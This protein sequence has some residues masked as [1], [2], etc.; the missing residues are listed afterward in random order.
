[1]AELTIDQMMGKLDDRIAS[2]VK[3]ALE[4]NGLG[5]VK[6]TNSPGTAGVGLR[7]FRKDSLSEKS[8]DEMSVDERSLACARVVRYMYRAGG[9]LEAAVD[10][11]HRAGDKT[12]AESCE[13]A[14]AGG[15]FVDGG[16]LLPTEFTSAVI[17]LLAPKST[18][19]SFGVTRIPMN[20]GSITLPFIA[21][22]AQASYVQEN[23]AAT[24]SQPG[25]G[26]LQ[27]SD[28]KLI[29]LVATSND[30]L[31]NGG[32]TADRVIRDDIA[33]AM[34]VKM[35]ITL[36]RSD[37]SNGEPTG[38]LHHADAGNLVTSAG[39]TTV[40]SATE[41]LTDAMQRLEDGEVELDGAGWI[42]NPRTKKFLMAARDG[43]NN[44]V[45]RDE[46]IAGT[47]EGLPFRV[48]SQIPRTLGGGNETEV[49]LAHFETLVLAE[50]EAMAIEAFPGGSYEE[51]G[52]TKSGISRDQT[53]IRAISLHDFG[54]R[55][56]GK[57]I[58]VIQGVK[59]GT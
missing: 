2:S 7:G 56:R 34:R 25:F 51:G 28:K 8:V 12:I 22:G 15:I 3:A 27:L 33:R 36:I 21:T 35:D 4:A 39:L 57:E 32:A 1:M 37:G 45:W 50:N 13:K 24:P 9:T 43:N 55:Q 47:I 11:M 46:M 23:T 16:A 26:Q 5:E 42:I 52:T 10:L 59:W 54:A 53:P 40:V 48:T 20:T 44:R 17:E 31:R 41:E 18:V 30:L 29:T 58:A 14:L 6:R 38:M 49:Y 19:L